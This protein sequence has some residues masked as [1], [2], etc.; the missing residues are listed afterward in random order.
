MFPIKIYHHPPKSHIQTTRSTTTLHIWK[1]LLRR[2]E[3][4]TT[5]TRPAHAL[6]NSQFYSAADCT[7]PHVATHSLRWRNRPQNT[8]T[9]KYWETRIYTVVNNCSRDCFWG[10][11]GRSVLTPIGV[12]VPIIAVRL[13]VTHIIALLLSLVFRGLRRFGARRRWRRPRGPTPALF[14]RRQFV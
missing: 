13:A 6:P 3:I 4:S 11:G 14:G 8:P 9:D 7:Q 5:A 2:V 10:S 1:K 12:A